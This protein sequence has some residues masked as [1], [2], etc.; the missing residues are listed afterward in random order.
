MIEFKD[1][2]DMSRTTETR[3]VGY[4]YN[5]PTLFLDHDELCPSDFNNPD[6]Q[7]LFALGKKM[8]LRG[9]NTLT[10][11]DIEMFVEQ[12]GNE[13]IKEGYK[14]YGGARLIDDMHYIFNESENIDVYIDDLKKWK[15]IA[16][17]SKHF[18]IEKK[19]DLIRLGNT[20]FNDLY[21]LYTAKL[22]NVFVN[23]NEDVHTQGIQDNLEEL[24]VEANEGIKR[25][26]PFDSPILSETING[27]NLGQITLIGGQSGSG[28]STWLIQQILTSVFN[29]EEAAVFFLNEQ[30]AKKFQQELLTWIVNNV[31][32]KGTNRF[33]NKVRW[34]DGGFTDEEFSWLYEAK[35]ILENKTKN[36]KIIVVEFKTYSH[37]VVTRSI[38]KYAALGVKIF[39]IDT[40]KLSSDANPKNP[41][42]LEMMNQM[43]EFDDLVKP[44]NLNVALV[45]TLQLGKGA[46]VSRYL[47]ANDLG[48]SK[49]I[50]DV[51]SVC[52]LIR[53]MHAD[54][55]AGERNAV[56]VVKPIGEE[57]TVNV[58][59]DPTKRHSIIF[60][61]KNRNGVAQDFQVVARHEFGTF[62]YEEMGKSY[63]S[64][65][66]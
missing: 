38:K 42:W 58:E 64:M 21:D 20:S 56:K 47:S 30:D 29:H 48:M 11:M 19:E 5:N 53:K 34:R 33:F 51:A 66:V 16:E 9:Y 25:G 52:L 27:I 54:E 2:Q 3:I 4:L 63:I 62:K 24:I 8:A 23:I 43:R 65:G 61:E 49:N 44:S 46:I 39:A 10:S 15:A 40:F 57:S 12:T 36:N 26:L 13:K 14:E 31:V 7:F 37:K 55:Y 32:L 35:E 50:I 1:I 22:N 28:K 17:I 18:T 59:L 60:I 6:W 45:C 41:F